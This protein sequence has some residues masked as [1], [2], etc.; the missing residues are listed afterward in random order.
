M[1][2]G[3]SCGSGSCTAGECGPA[4]TVPHVGQGPAVRVG[5]GWGGVWCGVF[6]HVCALHVHFRVCACAACVQC[7]CVCVCVDCMCVCILHVYC[8]RACVCTVCALHVCLCMAT[9]CL[10]VHL[11]VCT[12]CVGLYV[13]VQFTPVH[14][15]MPC[16]HMQFIPVHCTHPCLACPEGAMPVHAVHTHLSSPVTVSHCP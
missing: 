2:S 3:W 4:A 15:L 8:A 11:C 9:C 13:H 14:T 6:P 16:A 5:M 12:V 10:C 1:E 7:M